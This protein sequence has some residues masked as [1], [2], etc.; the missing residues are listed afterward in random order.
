M[1]I[2][3]GDKVRIK[4]VGPWNQRTRERPAKD[5]RIGRVAKIDFRTDDLYDGLVRVRSIVLDVG[6]NYVFARR[7]ELEPV[8]SEGETHERR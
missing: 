2:A 6:G 7:D 5:G 1:N 4:G 8:N 3:I